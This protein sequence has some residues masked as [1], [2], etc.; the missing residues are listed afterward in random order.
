M[1]KHGGSGVAGGIWFLGF[2]GSAV[3]FIQQAA[4][5]GV[6]VV[7]FLKALVWPAF[8]VYNILKFLEM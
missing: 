1:R 7:G 5:F 2:V 3:Y 6:G 8:V 4:T